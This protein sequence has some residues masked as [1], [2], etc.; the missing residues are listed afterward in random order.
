MPSSSV[1]FSSLKP[2]SFT[3]ISSSTKPSSSSVTPSSSSSSTSSVPVDPLARYKINQND[4]NA[5]FTP[6]NYDNFAMPL[7]YDISLNNNPGY[8]QIITMAQN[9]YVGGDNVKTEIGSS[10]TSK[11]FQQ[12]HHI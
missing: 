2:S 7:A 4:W 8:A 9:T 12:E 5:V 10:S 3:I 11:Q 1:I 6:T